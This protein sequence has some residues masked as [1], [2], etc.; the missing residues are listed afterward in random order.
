MLISTCCAGQRNTQ[1]LFLRCCPQFLFS[2]IYIYISVTYISSICI[3]ISTYKHIYLFISISS[4]SLSYICIYHLYLFVT[5]ISNAATFFF[6]TVFL[7]TSA[8]ASP[9]QWLQIC[10]YSSFELEDKHFTNR[11]IS[12]AHGKYFICISN[13]PFILHRQL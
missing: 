8:F 2:S 4:L 7:S 11:D 13:S 10:L 3:S 5:S 9:G 12:P 6:A 1:V